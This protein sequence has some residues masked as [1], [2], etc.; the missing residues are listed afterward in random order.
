[1]SF[2]IP[3][4]LWKIVDKPVNSYGSNVMHFA[5]DFLGL[6]HRNFDLLFSADT[7]KIFA[8]T[9]RVKF[10]NSASSVSIVRDNFTNLLEDR[11]VNAMERVQWSSGGEYL[12][13]ARVI[14]RYS[15]NS[16]PLLVRRKEI[17]QRDRDKSVPIRA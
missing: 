16:F 17:D 15:K 13:E 3:V 5:I 10:S 2:K 6:F 1:M 7:Q 14:R 12:E 9:D 11:T 4:S 8:I